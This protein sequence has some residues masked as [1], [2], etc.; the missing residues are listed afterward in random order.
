MHTSDGVA[1][2]VQCAGALAGARGAHVHL[3]ESFW[4]MVSDREECEERLT[5]VADG[6]RGDGLE[7][8]VHLRGGDAVD[9]IID[10]AEETAAALIVVDPRA[11]SAVMPWR[12]Y[13]MVDRVCARA[14]CDVLIA[15]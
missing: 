6:L 15:R 14:P 10:V 8:S 3:V 12:P 5:S 9:A 7:V 1:L 4:P 11:S 2:A 13:S